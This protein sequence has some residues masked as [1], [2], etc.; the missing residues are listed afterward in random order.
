MKY[1][2]K[3]NLCN[4]PEIK[5]TNQNKIKV[6]IHKFKFIIIIISFFKIYN[7]NYNNNRCYRRVGI[8]DR[9]F[10]GVGE[11]VQDRV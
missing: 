10:V 6:I 11:E 2:G 5:Q 1:K 7:Y 8:G 4:N 3:H 9:K